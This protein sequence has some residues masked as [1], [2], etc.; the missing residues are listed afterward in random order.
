MTEAEIRLL[1]RVTARI[2]FVF[3]MGAFAGN[4][5]LTL[6]PADL[7]R[8]MAEKKRDFLAGL[9]ISHTAHPGGLLAFLMTL[10]WAPASQST[11]YGGG[12]VLLVLDGLGLSRSVA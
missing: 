3:F 4:A 10:G 2:S 8:K 7:S 11:L 1:L 5:L 9:A 6:W 12:W